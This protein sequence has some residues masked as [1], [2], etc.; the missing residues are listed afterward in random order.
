MRGITNLAGS[1]P[2]DPIAGATALIAEPGIF[3]GHRVI[4]ANDALALFPDEARLFEKS[5][6]AARRQSG[7]ARAAA[8]GLLSRLGHDG[9]AILKSPSGAPIWPAGIVGSLAH[10]A[11][12]A[13]AAI[14]LAREF[15]GVGIDIEP[16]EDLP[17]D[18]VDLVATPTEK[19]RYG[20]AFLRN[21]A[22]FVAKEAVYKAVYPMDGVF[23]DFQDIEVDF[24]RRIAVLR[25]GRA[26]S[27]RVETS[28]HVIALAFVRQGAC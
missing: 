2:V 20:P 19:A 17:A 7:A 1:A 9:A 23:L 11:R 12:L 22:L 8:R 15:A 24:Q 27:V 13:I 14:A 28:S 25:N 6:L 18:L 16:D 26:V 21:R 4:S 3:I 5:S 10:D